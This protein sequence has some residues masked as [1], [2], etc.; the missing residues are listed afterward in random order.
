MDGLRPTSWLEI[1]G[2]VWLGAL[3]LYGVK[4]G[5]DFLFSTEKKEK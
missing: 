4:R 2:L 1:A 3:L 5:I